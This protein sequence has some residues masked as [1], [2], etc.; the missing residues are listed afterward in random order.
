MTRTVHLLQAVKRVGPPLGSEALE[1]K[2]GFCEL[3]VRGRGT[4]GG[5]FADRRTARGLWPERGHILT[6]TRPWGA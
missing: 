3:V 1:G 2:A 6:S 4:I 5:R